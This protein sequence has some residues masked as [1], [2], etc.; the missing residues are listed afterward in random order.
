MRLSEMTGRAGLVA[1]VLASLAL[2]GCQRAE[3]GDL[4]ALKDV[5]ADAFLVG[6]ALDRHHIYAHDPAATERTVREPRRGY[7]YRQTL[8]VD[9]AAME[10]TARQFNSVTAENVMKW[11]EIHPRPG[12]YD[13]DAADR[14]VDFAEANGMFM[15]GHTLVWHSQTPGW[16]F[17][18]EQ[19]NELTREALLERMREHIHTVAG[20]YRGRV[21]GWDVVNEAV[22]ADGTLRPSRWQRIIGDDF[23]EHAF[24]YAREADPDAELYYNDYSLENASKRAGVIRLVRQL[25]QNG[26]PITGVGSQSHLGLAGFPDLAEI[27]RMIVELGETGLDVMITELDIN[28]LPRPA[29]G[30]RPADM[31]PYVDGLPDEVQQELAQRYGELFEVY[32]RHRDVISRVTFWNVTDGDSWLNYLPVEGRVNHPLLFDRDAQPKPAFH[33]VVRVGREQR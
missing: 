10:L 14:L 13:F 2:P 24:R 19:G 23:I 22:N 6:A 16:V 33:E 1:V 17:E 8:M 32:L 28:V 27:E 30:T 31:N 20:R 7:S 5:F 4:P 26:V 21:Q 11:E 29:P 12:E 9:P 15:V 3:A 18:D 25:Q